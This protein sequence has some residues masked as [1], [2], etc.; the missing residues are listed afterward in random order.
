MRRSAEAGD[1]RLGTRNAVGTRPPVPNRVEVAARPHAPLAEPHWVDD[2][3]WPM[4][5]S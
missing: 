3:P 1:D 5:A 4:T 2:A